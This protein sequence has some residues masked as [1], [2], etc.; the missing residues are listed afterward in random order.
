MHE[1]FDGAERKQPNP[2]QAALSQFVADVVYNPG[3]QSS[4]DAAAS[5]RWVAP[6]TQPYRQ[7]TAAH[8]ETGDFTVAQ[9]DI[10]QKLDNEFMEEWHGPGLRA[11]LKGL[12]DGTHHVVPL[13]IPG[14]EGPE[15]VIRP[16]E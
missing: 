11:A 1:G 12:V 16:K 6:P 3:A 7:A 8:N 5:G 13:F 9:I 10:N 14:R 15:W 2:G 4:G